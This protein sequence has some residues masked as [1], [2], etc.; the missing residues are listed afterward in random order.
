MPMA[1]RGR[2]FRRRDRAGLR[3]RN[4]AIL[5]GVAGGYFATSLFA[6]P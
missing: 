6:G 4:V 5:P 3:G 1:P 2:M